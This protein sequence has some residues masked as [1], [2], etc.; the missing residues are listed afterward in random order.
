M[1]VLID[2]RSFLIGAAALPSVLRSAQSTKTRWAL[3]SD[4]HIAADPSDTFRGFNPGANLEKAVSQVLTARCDGAI[5]NGDL[6]RQDG[7]PEDYRRFSE[8]ISPVTARTPVALSLGNHDSRGIAMAYFTHVA[9]VQKPVPNR[10]VSVIEAGPVRVVVLD[11]LFETNKM[12]G[13]LGKAQRDWLGAFL[14][15]N[16]ERPTV[17]LVH[18]TLNDSD[19]ALLDADRLLATVDAQRHVKAIFYGHSHAYAYETRA[20][21][22]LVNIPAVGYNF[23]DFQPVGWVEAEFSATGADLTLHAFAGDRHMNGQSK[24]WSWRS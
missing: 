12:P 3:L 7:Q 6:A 4:T 5:V 24:S 9:G 11:S 19:T 20:G 15:A 1:P 16:V 2:R 8:I 13:L 22:H 18:H 14:S 10:W 17:I 23:V 21:L